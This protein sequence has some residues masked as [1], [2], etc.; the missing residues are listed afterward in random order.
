MGCQPLRLG[1]RVCCMHKHQDFTKRNGPLR[2]SIAQTGAI[3]VAIMIMSI[4]YDYH[5]FKFKSDQLISELM[6]TCETLDIAHLF[7]LSSCHPYLNPMI[8][9]YSIFNLTAT[10]FFTL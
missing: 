2:A 9:I 6:W 1:D 3:F 4:D 5:F 7:M 8:K 10:H